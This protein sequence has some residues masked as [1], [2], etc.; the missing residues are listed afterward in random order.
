MDCSTFSPANEV[1]AQWIQQLVS[2]LPSATA[3][4]AVRIILLAPNT[5]LKRHIRKVARLLS[6]DRLD[7]RRALAVSSVSELE[8]YFSSVD[9]LPL[10]TGELASLFAS[11][12]R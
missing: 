4:H 5:L 2:I 3:Q 8:L 9:G 7:S 10:S 1:P 12:G 11:P 6:F